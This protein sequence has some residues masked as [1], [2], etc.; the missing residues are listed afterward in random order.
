MGGV[1]RKGAFSRI[2]CTFAQIN[3]STRFMDNSREPACYLNETEINDFF[4]IK[5]F[6]I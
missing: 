3:M 6:T 5:N 1:N 2:I 4:E